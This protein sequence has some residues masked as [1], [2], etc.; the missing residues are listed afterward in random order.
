M[1]QITPMSRQM[2]LYRYLIFNLAVYFAFHMEQ[3]WHSNDDD[4]LE[5]N[6]FV[7]S[8]KFSLFFFVF[9]LTG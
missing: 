7:V 4:D 5:R 2:Y 3:P 6:K 1:H 9:F 8:E